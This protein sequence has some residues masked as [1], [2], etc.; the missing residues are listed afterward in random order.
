MKQLSEHQ[1]DTSL[2]Q[3]VSASKQYHDDLNKVLESFESTH[4]EAEISESK[5]YQALV[6]AYHYFDRIV[7]G[8]NNRLN[9][10]SK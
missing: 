5:Q 1:V 6:L 2:K 10:S 9:S 8:V 7:A 3:V 4:S